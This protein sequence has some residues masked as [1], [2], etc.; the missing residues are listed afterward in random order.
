MLFIL[1]NE[2]LHPFEYTLSGDFKKNQTKFVIVKI[3]ICID[4]AC[5]GSKK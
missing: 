3:D 5:S 2:S 4:V 1:L